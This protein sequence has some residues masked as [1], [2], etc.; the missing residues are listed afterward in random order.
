MLVLVNFKE[1]E[2]LTDNW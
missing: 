1:D 2:N